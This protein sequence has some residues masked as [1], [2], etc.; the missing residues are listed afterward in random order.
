MEKFQNQRVMQESQRKG[1]FGVVEMVDI[2]RQRE[3]KRPR[4]AFFSQDVNFW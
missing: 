2:P 1:K 4:G 3:F